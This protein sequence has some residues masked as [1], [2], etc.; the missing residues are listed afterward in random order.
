MWPPSGRVRR[1]S[2]GRIGP[3]QLD[4]GPRRISPDVLAVLAS[5]CALG[6][7]REYCPGVYSF[8][9]KD[10]VA[11][12]PADQITYLP[13]YSFQRATQAYNLALGLPPQMP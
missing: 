13:T 1:L 12:T 5:R 4:L 8:V 3:V 10:L 9:V 2:V 11:K 6:R 7:G